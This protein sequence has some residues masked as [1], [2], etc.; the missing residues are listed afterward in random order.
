M[1]GLELEALIDKGKG[2]EQV[3]VAEI[4]N[5][6]QHPNADR[7]TLC[8]VWDGD[9]I[10]KV[11]CGAAN[12]KQ[13]DKVALA[14]TGTVLPPGPKFEE[15]LKIKKAKIRGEESQGM[16]CAEDEL[17]LSEK[18]EGIMILE[19]KAELGQRPRR[20]TWL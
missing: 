6:T 20:Y 4:K 2:L 7:L 3:V 18:S 11:V 17:G 1:T 9:Q 15:G 8:E 10:H 13:G 16:L 14:K 5:L 19:D 12:M